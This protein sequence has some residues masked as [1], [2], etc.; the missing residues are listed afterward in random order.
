MAATHS[1]CCFLSTVKRINWALI[2]KLSINILYGT[3]TAHDTI[4]H[5]LLCAFSVDQVRFEP[6][7]RIIVLAD[8]F[9]DHKFSYDIW[10]MSH[11]YLND[12]GIL[13]K[14]PSS[15]K[16]FSPDVKAIILQLKLRLYI[17]YKWN[18]IDG[19]QMWPTVDCFFT[20][21]RST[22]VRR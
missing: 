14:A 16:T 1:R 3:W 7:H 9:C 11:E 13:V 8:I 19:I 4:Q 5:D 10:H 2:E 12:I 21:T 18:G 17:Q 20:Q 15:W 6:S 22:C